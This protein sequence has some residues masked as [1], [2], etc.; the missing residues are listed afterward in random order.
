MTLRCPD[1]QQPALAA[2]LSQAVRGRYCI[3]AWAGLVR[4]IEPSRQVSGILNL[5]ALGTVADIVNVG[6]T[7]YC[8]GSLKKIQDALTRHTALLKVSR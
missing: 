5:A 8:L 2:S 1:S 6:K 7:N 3:Q 4:H